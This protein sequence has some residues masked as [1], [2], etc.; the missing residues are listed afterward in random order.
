MTKKYLEPYQLRMI[1][2]EKQLFEKL[3]TLIGF[4]ASSK[5]DGLEEK[6]KDLL[7]QQGVH[8]GRYLEVLRERIKR[9]K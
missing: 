5:F 9:F 7:E 2:E 3:D 6:D 8:M 1:E 4:I